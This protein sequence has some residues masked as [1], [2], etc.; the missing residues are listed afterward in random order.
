MMINV[1]CKV[2][3]VVLLSKGC[4]R[5]CRRMGRGVPP[6]GTCLLLPM[7]LLGEKYIAPCQSLFPV[8]S[9]NTH[10]LLLF[11]KHLLL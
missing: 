6:A 10:S 5:H 7:A 2:T 9:Y 3:C 1:N 8:E 11:G 4:V